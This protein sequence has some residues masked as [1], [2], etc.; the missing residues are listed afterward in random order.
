ML[1]LLINI[2]LVCGIILDSFIAICLVTI[3]I[4][5]IALLIKII[6]KD[7]IRK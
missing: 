2:L 3:A 7:L 6:I 4:Y 5:I 1:N